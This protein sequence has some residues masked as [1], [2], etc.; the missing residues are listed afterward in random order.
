MSE[1]KSFFQKML[2]VALPITLQSI[3][4]ATLSLIDQV[5]VGYLGSNSI[6]GIGLS[7][8]FSSLF[9][10]TV[11]AIVTVAGIMISQ[12]LGSKNQQGVNY[13]FHLNLFFAAIVTAFFMILAISIPDTIMGLYSSDLPTVEVAGKYLRITAFGYLPIMLTLI[14]SA[15]LRNVGY[16]KLPFYAS[17]IAVLSN[18]GLNYLLIF[19][20][21]I[22][23]KMGYEGAALATTISRVIEFV[24]IFVVF[25]RIRAKE[26][27]KLWFTIKC[28][29]EFAKTAFHILGPIIVC[30]FLWSLGE[31]VYAIIYGHM[32][33]EACAAMTLTYPIQGIMIGLL[34][35]V[36]SAASILIGNRLGAN[37]K[38]E[39]Y[40][41]SKLFIRIT[42]I[43]ALIVGVIIVCF[44][45]FYVLLYNN[46]AA[47][48]Q[49]MA[50][51]ILYAYAIVF[52]AKV[53]NMVLGGGIIRSGGMTK[54]ILMVDMIGTWAIG[55]PVG[56]I[57]SFGLGLP[58]YLVYFLLSLEEGVRV[59]LEVKIF[60]SKKW[61]KNVTV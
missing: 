46:V 29:K 61:M 24:I 52:M 33:T 2:Q 17:F 59:L 30:E 32:G 39:A 7:S 44:S 49:E 25:L 12:Y 54:Y 6:A 13:S 57:C 55:V 37:Q 14:C 40:K 3:L 28:P 43:M 20:K 19:G 36:S 23:P 45:R 11:S 47:E 34:T 42:I 18:I 56:L 48:T 27:T 38:E 51:Y 10:V 1:N 9:S 41:E 53:L 15:Y 60:R 22:F 58:I 4:Q 5:M 31:N 21:W 16:A 50:V 8:K 26:E 35:G